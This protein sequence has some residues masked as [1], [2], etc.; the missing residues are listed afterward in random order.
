MTDATTQAK[1]AAT[2]AASDA[3]DLRLRASIDRSVRYPVLFF[4][5]SAAAWLF[6]A[7]IL[8]FLS[9][10]KLV[11]PDL[12]PQWTW[13][14]YG[15]LWPLHTNAL[16]YGWGMQ[17]GFGIM[18]WLMARLCRTEVRNSITLLVAGH[19]WN[20]GITVGFLA[21][22]MGEGS[23]MPWLEFPVYV[24]PLLALTY[25]TF[26][27]S[28]V[29]M[30]RLRRGGDLF[31]S[32]LYVLGA[33]LWFPWVY[34]TANLLIHNDAGAPVM[35]AGINAWF[36]SNL[37]Y[38]WFVPIALA[39]AYYLVPKISGRPIRSYPLAKLGFWSLA[40]FAG[41]TGFSRYNGGP[42][43]AW[44]TSVSG[45]ATIFILL[46][47]ILVWLN[48]SQSVKGGGKLAEYS[49]ALRFTTFG[50]LMFAL[51]CLLSALV[52]FYAPGRYLQF[53]H[54]TIGIDTLGIYGMFSMV[55]F[56]AIYFIVPRI[57]ACEWPSG[58]MI[59]FHFWFS[60][61]GILT[62]I[63]FMLFGGLAQGTAMNSWAT[64]FIASVELGNGYVIGRC[65]AWF[66]IA[67]ANL[68]FFYQL[69]L[70]FI[71]KGRKSEGAT[72][73]QGQPGAAA[74]SV[75]AVEMSHSGSSGTSQVKA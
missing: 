40:V 28:L 61:Y 42:F 5:T 1:S 37:V 43:P 18:L 17:A 52:G 21:M 9:G 60:S 25:I 44:M 66:L 20:V 70:M 27:V 67:V 46:A 64:D 56:G 63:C 49:P 38:F 68:A 13:L 69:A 48:L 30:F 34:I 39:A 4:F 29:Q 57:T 32:Q 47:A 55:A 53:S 16:I 10:I 73:L 50:M 6:V 3:E 12:G 45:A 24:W 8:G 62:V 36:M 54:A 35:K 2:L 51:F 72:L 33:A 41:W 71:G 23:S 58:K 19:V 7:T 31:I 59:N 11:N 75:E 22:A 14:T 74:T 26:T 65:L 15:R